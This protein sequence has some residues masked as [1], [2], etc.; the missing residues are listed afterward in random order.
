MRNI[1][2]K[3]ARKNEHDVLSIYKRSSKAGKRAKGR[4]NGSLT[5][6]HLYSHAEMMMIEVDVLAAR[7]SHTRQ[8]INHVN[9]VSKDGQLTSK[10]F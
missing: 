9:L 6:F 5:Q 10:L 1:K 3:W 8:M 2:K 4:R 7:I